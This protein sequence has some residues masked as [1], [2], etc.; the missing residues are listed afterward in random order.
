MENWQK[1]F[2]INKLGASTYYVSRKG[3]PSWKSAVSPDFH[4]WYMAATW[5][6]E[7]WEDIMVE[8]ILLK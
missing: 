2:K 5:I 6:R 3:Q 7:Q 8:E 1:F 4:S